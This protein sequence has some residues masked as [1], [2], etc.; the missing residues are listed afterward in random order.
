MARKGFTLVEV[1][2]VVIIIGIL[3]A[4]AMPQ[5][6][7]TLE[8]SRSSEAFTNI[9]TIRTSLDRY[10]YERLAI[11]ADNDWDALDIENPNTQ[12]QRLYDYTFEDESTSATTRK[13]LV[14]AERVGDATT[15][16][17]WQQEDNLTG[18]IYR[19]ANL[20]GPTGP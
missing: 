19:S 15:Y 18:K 6:I 3:A 10:W 20:G 5:Y 14:T 17:K 1:L 12:T 7:R 2:I 11:P 8:K 9:G 16:V 4:I 13:Y